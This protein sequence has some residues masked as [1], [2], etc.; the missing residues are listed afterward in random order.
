MLAHLFVDC[1]SCCLTEHFAMTR[2]G[3]G[4]LQR[5]F[6]LP[7]EEGGRGWGGYGGVCGGRSLDSGCKAGSPR[8]MTGKKGGMGII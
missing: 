2:R 3:G 7:A 1:F 8:G 4:G 5:G 6:P